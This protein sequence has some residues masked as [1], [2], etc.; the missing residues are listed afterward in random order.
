MIT[1]MVDVPQPEYLTPE[2]RADGPITLAEYDPA[3]VEQFTREEKRIRG[4]LGSLA[5]EVHH[6]GSTSVPGLQAKPVIDIVL[7]VADSADEPAYVPQLEAAG[8]ALHLREPDWGEHRLLK[9]HNP[10]IQIH[11]FTV[12]Y[13]EVERMLLFRDRLRSHA[14]ERDLYEGAKRELAARQWR[15]VQ[16]YA[17]AKSSVVEGIIARA[18]ADRRSRSGGSDQND[19][20]A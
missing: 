7:L 6:V 18:Q 3:W 9:H 5:V 10:D 16:D 13:P 11:V 14:D 8:Y 20:G 15:Y 19:P 12:G 2:V 4:A 17:D 1:G